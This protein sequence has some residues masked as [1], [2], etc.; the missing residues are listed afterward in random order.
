M[1]VTTTNHLRESGRDASQVGKGICGVLSVE[2]AK[3]GKKLTRD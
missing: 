3:K 1:A 2:P